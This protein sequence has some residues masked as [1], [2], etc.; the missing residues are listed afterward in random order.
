MVIRRQNSR[1]ITIQPFNRLFQIWRMVIRRLFCRRIAWGISKTGS[2]NLLLLLF[3]KNCVNTK[4]WTALYFWACIWM[5]HLCCY[6]KSSS[7]SHVHASENFTIHQWRIQ[8]LS[9]SCN[10]RQNFYKTRMH[11]SRMRTARSSS[12]P[13]DSPPGTPSARDQA[14][15]LEPDPPGTRHPPRTRHPPPPVDRMIDRSKHITLPQT[16]FAGNNNTLAW[17]VGAPSEILDPPKHHKKSVC[18]QNSPLVYRL[19]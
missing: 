8:I 6:M 12:R 14:S 17:G 1:Q 3:A 13:G 2:T 18:P 7:H 9:F 5:W 16:S 11:S 15:S 10:F 19:D 4:K